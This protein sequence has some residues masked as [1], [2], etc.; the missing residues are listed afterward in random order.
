[1]KKTTQ[2]RSIQSAVSFGV[3]AL[4]SR[5][6]M[7]GGT[8]AGTV[9]N[10]L[11]GNGVIDANESGLAGRQIYLDLQGIDALV[12]GD[13]IATTNAA[14]AYSFSNLAAG[15]YLVR[16]VPLA[17]RVTAAPVWGGKFF[18]QL[19]AGQTA[20]NQ[21]FIDAPLTAPSLHLTNGQTLVAGMGNSAGT[22]S[23]FNADGSVD[24]AYGS[25]G[26]LTLPN[27][28]GVATAIA[29]LPDGR[30]S[31]TFPSQ[32]VTLSGTG[33]LDLSVTINTPTALVVTSPSPTSVHLTFNDN[34]TN[35]QSFTIE[36]STGA[37]GPWTAIGTVAGSTTTGS[38]GYDDNT[39]ASGTTYFYRVYGVSGTTLSAIAGPVS[40]TTATV[41][42]S[43]ATISGTVFSDTNANRQLDAGEAGLANVKV[44]LDLQGVDAFAA[45][46]PIATTDATG[47]YTFSNLPASNYLVRLLPA[48][49]RVTTSPIWGGKYFVP[50]TK[51]QVVSGDDFLSA[52]VTTPSATLTNGQLLVTGTAGGQATFARYNGDGSIDT[53]Y[54]SLGILTVPAVIG[55]A[56]SMAVL[57]DGTLTV[58]Y[59]NQT[60]TLSATGAVTSISAAGSISAPTNLLAVAISS[61]ISVSFTDTSTNEQSIVIERGTAAAGPWTTVATLP[62]SPSV[63]V[64]GWIDHNTSPSATY[65]YRVYAASGS[66]RSSI[67]GPVSAT[68]VPTVV[69][70]VPS[71]GSAWVPY[72]QL[73]GQ[74][75][76]ANKFP[77]LT[78]A[79]ITI[80]VIDRGIDY[81][82]P[83]L[84][85]DKILTGYNFRDNNTNILDDYGH[86]TG[87]AGL[88][89]AN[90]YTY[91]GLYNQG[92]A[93]GVKIVDL[94]QESSAGV[95]AALDWVIA[96]H[97]AYNIQVVN[98]TD[99]IGD[100]VPGAW[101]PA[102]Y[103][104]ELKTV[105]DLG[106]FISSPVGNGE[107]QFGPNVPIDNPAANPYVTGAG[108]ITLSDTFYADSRRGP[109]LSILAPAYNVTMP[110]YARNLNSIG[111][112]QFDDNYNGTPIITSYGTGT[113]WASA[114]TAGTAVLLK[115]IS[116]TLTPDQI[117]QIMKDSGTPVLDPTNNVYYS[118]LNIEKAIEL[119]YQRLGLV[120]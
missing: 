75:V 38:R 114:Y 100:I 13:P 103:L 46:D 11:N 67:T 43:G 47:H 30:I 101:N 97:T 18:I 102:V 70:N 55:Q 106:I 35:E 112:D 1:M 16:E 3:E 60:V 115:Q 50:L 4:E 108:G 48:A 57:P 109:G 58:G 52:P 39:A 78:G 8:I 28:T 5:T 76:A 14:G 69:A 72:A 29:T 94:K 110:Y 77:T 62:G 113:S 37:N 45:G 111:Y 104:P 74:D 105:H 10:D 66:L 21:N 24:T 59:P 9:Y 117:Q 93:P 23:R 118:R 92:V 56:I 51:G 2:L 61:T 85:A 31:V 95:K 68:T 6:L 41:V 26:V 84:G 63:G 65:W 40:I 49:G 120:P 87:V 22:I 32:T 27:V 107:V 7:S 34:S 116:P 15:N 119:T 99:F 71:A 42:T 20:A 98:I 53:T 82:A 25:L 96:N 19:A 64:V 44:Y 90:G 89:A 17:G 83:M 73:L 12:A 88:V 36:R 33:T 86:G 54:G 91:N 79:G 80:A 81:N